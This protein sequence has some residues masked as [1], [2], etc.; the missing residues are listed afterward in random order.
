MS[1]QET[2]ASLDQAC[3]RFSRFLRE[4]GYPEQILWVENPD[5]ICHQW[6]LWVRARTAQTMRGRACQKYEEGIRNGLGVWL[7]AFSELPG[8]TIAA[9][10]LPKDEDAAQ[11]CLMPRSGLKLTVAAK[12][13]SARRVTNR[14]T[15]L[16]LSL[17]YGAASR[18]F[19][20]DY[21]G[22]S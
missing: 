14:L 12:K 18:S 22:C 1:D 10:I 15:W 11:R 17:R 2:P 8:T 9:V 13:F 6:Q 3:Q 16:I 21:L 4:N 19:W 20:D 7:Q 5:V